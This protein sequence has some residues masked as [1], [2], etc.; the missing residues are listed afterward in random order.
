MA[1]GRSYYLETITRRDGQFE[2]LQ[3]VEENILGIRK[4]NKNYNRMSLKKWC[5]IDI[6]HKLSMNK[7]K[8]KGNFPS[9][10]AVLIDQTYT[11]NIYWLQFE[12]GNKIFELKSKTENEMCKNQ[13]F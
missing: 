13:A 4:Y 10:L 5:T 1:V 6:Q 3:T 2:K 11:K 7:I 9:T 12:I 8:T